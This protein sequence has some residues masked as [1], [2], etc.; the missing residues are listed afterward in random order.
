[1]YPTLSRMAR[2]Y[3]AIQGSSMPSE[4]AFSSGGITDHSRRNRLTPEVF[5]ALQLLKSAYRNGHI[6]VAA[7]AAAIH[8]E[9]HASST[10]ITDDGLYLTDT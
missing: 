1:M 5:E 7:E 10:D 3:L 4:R 2:D 6:K 8:V 9:R